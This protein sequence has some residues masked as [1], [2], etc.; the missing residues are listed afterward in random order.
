MN[1]QLEGISE[2]MLQLG[3]SA[4]SHANRHAAYHAAPNPNWEQLSVLQAAHATEILIKARIAEEHPLLIFEKFPKISSTDISL[5]QLFADGKTIDWNELP[6]RLW[7]TTGMSIK[8][9]DFFKEFG[10]MRNAIQHFGAIPNGFSLGY[11]SLDFIFHVI[12]P[13]INDCWNLFAVDFDEDYD[14]AEN[15]PEILL[16]NE[17]A[18]LVSHKITLSEAHWNIDWERLSDKY[19][20]MMQMRIRKAKQQISPSN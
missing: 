2:N 14:S 7:A 13:F 16:N 11:F 15:F 5:E 3:L 18:F 4:L 9:I 10:K 12:D 1:P 8:D 19:K 6:N 20:F 17:I